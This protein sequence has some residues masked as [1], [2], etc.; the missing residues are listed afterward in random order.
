MKNLR[1]GETGRETRVDAWDPKAGAFLAVNEHKRTNRVA[2]QIKIEIADILT[3]K[4]KDPRIGFVTVTSVEISD[5]LKHAKVFVSVHED[6]KMAFIGLKKATPFVR[7]ELA[8]RLQMRRIPEIAFLPDTSTE[9]VTHIL[10]LLD[11]IEKG[12]KRKG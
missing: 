8:R 12:D 10:D 6:E 11:Q 7:G 4:T 3:K 5:D 2:D 9:K 1:F